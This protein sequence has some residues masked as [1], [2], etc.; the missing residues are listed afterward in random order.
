MRFNLVSVVSFSVLF[1][2]SLRSFNFYHFWGVRWL[3]ILS[4]LTLI[5]FIPFSKIYRHLLIFVFVFYLVVLINVMLSI[6]SFNLKPYLFSYI[7]F[8]L[9]PMYLLLLVGFY[10]ERIDLLIKHLKWVLGI[11]LFFFYLQLSVF[12]VSGHIIDFLEII[13]NE[14]QR[15]IGGI[16]TKETIIRTVGL[17]NEP[18]SYSIFANSMLLCL[19]VFN[20]RITLLVGLTILS[21]IL[22]FSASGIMF[23]A[24][25]LLFTFI[26]KSFLT[27]NVMLK[28]VILF[29]GVVII[30]FFFKETRVYEV[31]T[32]KIANFQQSPSYQYR[33]GNVFSEFGD[34]N[35]YQKVFGI[36]F[37]N[38]TVNENLGSF[39]SQFIIQSGVLFITV[40]SL[41]FYWLFRRYKLKSNIIAIILILGLSTQVINHLITWYFMACILVISYNKYYENSSFNFRSWQWRC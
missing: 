6:L 27:K 30:K 8:V 17:F 3:V 7:G 13:T 31:F 25:V 12:L 35:I 41:L 20:K 11:H 28:T 16:Y 21:I 32:E 10:K 4:L 18:A 5:V 22:S 19:L 29:F 14:P 9:S 39:F 37:G 36:G 33:I 15:T 38:L 34:L 24:V 26:K 2:G 23:L 1:L 40:F